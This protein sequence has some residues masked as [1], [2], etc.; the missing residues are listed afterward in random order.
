MGLEK[1]S[2]KKSGGFWDFLEVFEL[3]FEGFLP[4]GATLVVF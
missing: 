1:E 3:N 2:K 4:V